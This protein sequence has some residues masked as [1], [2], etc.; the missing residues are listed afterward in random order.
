MELKQLYAEII[1]EHNLNP[2]HRGQIKNPSMELRGVNPSCG[3]NIFL[4]IEFEDDKVKDAVFNGSGCAISQASVDMMCDLIIGQ[5]KSEALHL[6]K[7]FNSMIQGTA[8]EEEIESLDEA[9]LLKDIAHMP[10]RVKCAVLGWKTMEEMLLSD[11]KTSCASE[12]C[13][14]KNCPLRKNSGE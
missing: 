13:D 12:S 9:S 5:K 2:S 14:G 1:N 11:K 6:S 8:S 3:D 7:I 4:Q 10:A